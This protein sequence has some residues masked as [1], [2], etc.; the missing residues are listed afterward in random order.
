MSNKSI[1]RFLQHALFVANND[2]RRFELEQ[3]LQTIVP[4]DDAAIE[5]VQI[6]SRKTSAFQRNE[7]TQIRRNHRQN[8]EHH[9]IR[10]RVRRGKALHELQPLREFLADLF[11]LAFP[12][13]LFQLFVELGQIDLGE[14]L[15]DRF[16][17]HAGDE[18]LAVLLLRFAIFGFVQ[19]LR[20]LQRRLAG[21]DDD[22]ILVIDDALELRA[23][24]CR[25]SGRGAKACT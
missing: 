9:P 24:S 2:V 14:K 18:I 19:K 25:A 12:H 5:I 8:V 11:A 4:V 15:L 23:R 10:P 3:I 13:R 21:I 20:L 1:D 16:R 17:A 22:V 7:R 6:G